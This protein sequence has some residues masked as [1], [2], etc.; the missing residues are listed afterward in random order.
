MANEIESSHLL[1]FLTN[2]LSRRFVFDRSLPLFIVR[3]RKN[4]RTNNLFAIIH[5]CPYVLR[6]KRLGIFTRKYF[7]DQTYFFHSWFQTK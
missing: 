1:S 6:S 3:I 5:N 4:I 7:R 2:N